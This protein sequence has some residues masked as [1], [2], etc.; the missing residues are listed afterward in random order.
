MRVG[1]TYDLR[2]EYLARGFSEDETAE[3]DR[4]DT[5]DA[6]QAALEGLGHTAVRIG[7]IQSLVERLAASD[8]WD[9]VFNISE[10]LYGFGR[11]SQ[12]P[13]LLDAYQIPYTFSDPLTMALCLHK[14]YAKDVVAARGVPTP[15]FALVSE[16]HE[17]RT[18][19]VTFPAIA[20]PVAEGTGKGVGIHSK[21]NDRT[22]LE[23]V[24]AS[25]LSTYR[26]PVLVEGFLPGRELT[27]SIVGTGARAEALGSLEILLRSGAEPELYSY[28][29][30]AHWEALVDYQSVSAASDPAAA[31]AESVALAAWRALGC[32][33]A[34]RV[35]VRADADGKM[36]FIEAN[37]LAGM[38]PYHSD[39]PMQ[40]T[41]LGITYQELVARIL[42]S[43]SE[44]IGPR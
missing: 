36:C 17:A 33:D 32:R 30:K 16:A 24:C 2:S 25:L 34:G 29:N 44:R 23:R 40:A 37:P 22:Q 41:A 4:D 19:D 15:A 10:G 14:A 35:D 12:V 3:L 11:E 5:I 28:E 6:L 31:D 38:H 26:Q 42:H 13:A 7:S 1:L 39:L 20:K 27:V 18:V 8:R 21:V 43:A 9:L